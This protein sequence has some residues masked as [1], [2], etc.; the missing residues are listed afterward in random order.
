MRSGEALGIGKDFFRPWRFVVVRNHQQAVSGVSGRLE[1]TLC[2]NIYALA[3]VVL[4]PRRVGVKAIKPTR[5]R[6][7]V[8]NIVGLCRKNVVQA[9]LVSK[10]PDGIDDAFVEIET[11]ILVGPKSNT[12]PL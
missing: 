9:F 7:G 4:T 10:A 3:V 6:K 1:P 2:K 5:L 8:E 12:P 11:V